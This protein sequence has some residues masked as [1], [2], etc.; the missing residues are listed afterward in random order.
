MDLAHC[1]SKFI[2]PIATSISMKNFI[3][4]IMSAC[5]LD[6]YLLTRWLAPSAILHCGQ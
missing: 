1:L 5:F 6:R 4:A 2:R 3:T